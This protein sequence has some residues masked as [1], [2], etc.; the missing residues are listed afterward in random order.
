[1]RPAI[2]AGRYRMEKEIGRG[3]TAVVYRAWDMRL[4]KHWAIKRIRKGEMSGVPPGRDG[5][6]AEYRLLNRLEHPALPRVVDVMETAEETVIVMDLV[7]GETLEAYSVRHG[8]VDETT[9]VQWMMQLA[10][11]LSFLH[12]QNP[13]VVHRDIKPSNIIRRKN[14]SLVLLDLGLAEEGCD[15]AAPPIGTRGYAPPEQADGGCADPRADVYALGMTIFSLLTG[16]PPSEEA[17]GAAEQNVGRTL[18]FLSPFFSKILMQCIA[19]APEQ[20]YVDGDALRHALQEGIRLRRK[21][22]LRKRVLRPVVL[23]GM[24]LFELGICFGRGVPAQ[25]RAAESPVPVQEKEGETVRVEKKEAQ[26]ANREEESRRERSQRWQDLLAWIRAYRQELA[27]AGVPQE[28]VQKMIDE[29]EQ[30]M[31]KEG[32]EEKGTVTE[33]KS[34]QCEAL[35]SA[36]RDTYAVVTPWRQVTEQK[37]EGERKDEEEEQ[38]EHETGKEMEQADRAGHTGAGLQHSRDRTGTCGRRK[39]AAV[40]R[41]A[42][43]EDRRGGGSGSARRSASSDRR[44]VGTDRNTGC[45]AGGE[46][47]CTAG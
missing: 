12:G 31:E 23:S 22:Q 16:R 10:E 33:K 21:R 46:H 3:G 32:G 1:M 8:S 6:V 26:R 5:A 19:P 42:S 41:T 35:R 14:G 27:V 43:G 39:T 36:V 25:I 2:L 40:D 44:T 18:P 30:Q 20:R 45:T 11:V 4:R 9:A 24:I 28:T 7:E 15:K 34:M 38:K 37:E 13:P 29:I 47:R 17:A